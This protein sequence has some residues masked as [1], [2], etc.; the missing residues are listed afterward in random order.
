M[1]FIIVGYPWPVPSAHVELT[2]ANRQAKRRHQTTGTAAASQHPHG[3]QPVTETDQER[4]TL[5]A[6]KV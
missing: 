3:Q 5:T 4:R 2:G 6:A 1:S